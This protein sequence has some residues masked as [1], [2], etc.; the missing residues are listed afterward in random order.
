MHEKNCWNKLSAQRCIWKNCLQRLPPVMRDLRSLKKCQWSKKVCKCSVSDGKIFSF[1]EIMIPSPLGGIIV[2]PTFWQGSFENICPPVSPLF[3]VHLQ[4][5]TSKVL[6]I[7]LMSSLRSEWRHQAVFRIVP[8]QYLSCVCFRMWAKNI[9]NEEIF[10]EEKAILVQK[11]KIS[12][13][14]YLSMVLS[15]Q[16]PRLLQTQKI[17]HMYLYNWYINDQA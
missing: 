17:V 11:L 13:K 10:S 6:E 4:Q 16:H 2:L 12:P 14:C 15:W 9:Q 8:G 1:L 7:M 5:I 3:V